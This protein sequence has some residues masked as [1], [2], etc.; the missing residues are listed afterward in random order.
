MN[1]ITKAGTVTLIAGA[2]V[3][4]GSRLNS[5][6]FFAKQMPKVGLY[7]MKQVK[8]SVVCLLKESV[9]NDMESIINNPKISDSTK[10]HYSSY[11]RIMQK[12]WIET[13]QNSPKYGEK[14]FVTINYNQ[15]KREYYGENG[16]GESAIDDR[17]AIEGV[18]G[19]SPTCDDFMVK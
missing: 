17:K 10:Q 9:M 19:R 13:T 1:T 8:D 12:N 18:V 4:G 3:F 2:L 5:Q 11:F 15:N 16:K 14:V 6:N 7:D